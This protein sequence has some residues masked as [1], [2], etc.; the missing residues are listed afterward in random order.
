MLKVKFKSG[1]GIRLGAFK[2]Q[3]RSEAARRFPTL[4][5]SF[6]PGDMVEQV[7]NFGANTPIEVAVVGKDLA[8]SRKIAENI[9]TSLAAIPH[10]RDVQFGSPLDYPGLNITI[11][12]TRAGQL[13][14][15][16]DDISKSLVAATSSSRFTQPN[17]WLDRATGTA[18]QVQVEVPQ[19]QMNS[20]ADV[21]EIP[22]SPKTSDRTGEK[23]LAVR[24]VADWNSI[25]TVGEYDRLNQQR[26]VTVTANIHGQ[27]VAGAVRDVRGAVE[28][29]GAFPT[30]VKIMLRGQ[31]DVLA[32]TM[33]EL[34]TGLALA[35]VVMLLLLAANFQSFRLAAIIL[36]TVPAVLCGSLALL[37]LAGKTLN[38][39]SFMGCIMAI[40][41]SV[42]NGILLITNAETLRKEQAVSSTSVDNTD[43]A[44]HGMVNRL[45]PIL[46]T[47][48]A[49]TAGMIPMALGLGEGGD[50]TS[51]LGIA[52]IGGLLVSTL[53]TL[54]V[55]PVLYVAARGTAVS[56][57]V[58]LDPDDAESRYFRP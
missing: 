11:D 12:R 5:L 2:E 53:A 30:G 50:Q 33:N 15:T 18:Y 41:V 25:T 3:I 46:M 7:M 51:P 6:E 20:P 38:I 56:R 37:L 19:F 23:R 1:T 17:Y 47:A 42:A 24:D 31:A 49:M 57:S 54:V 44:L 16:V 45:R 26:Y 21:E 34:Q 8:Q 40:G 36:A 43:V 52:V 29:L 39:Q 58:S 13:G 28:K 10:L 32:Q 9:R 4:K 48:F 35:I 14:L 55:S 22:L 27:D